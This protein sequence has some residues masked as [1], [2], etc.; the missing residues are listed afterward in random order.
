MTLEEYKKR[1]L[2]WHKKTYPKLIHERETL[3]LM[4]D[5]DWREYM[6][7]FSPEEVCGAIQADA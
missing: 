3:R 5:K 4:P 7:D 6:K 2:A 1:A